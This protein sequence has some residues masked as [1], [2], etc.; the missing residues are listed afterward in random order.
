MKIKKLPTTK[1]QR[2]KTSNYWVFY[3]RTEAEK[4]IIKKGKI[5]SVQ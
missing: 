3:P 5:A 4:F 2:L 1:K